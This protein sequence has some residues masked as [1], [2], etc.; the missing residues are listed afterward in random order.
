MS[1]FLTNFAVYMKR[2]PRY[3][4]SIEDESRLETK[5]AF[6]ASPL[7]WLFLGG[8]A[9][10]S[11]MV[12]GVFVV[13]LSPLRMLLPGYLKESERAET[14]MQ[15]LRLDSIR[16]A[17]EA[18]ASFLNN[19]IRVISPTTLAGASDGATVPE[20]ITAE[21]DTIPKSMR[22]PL[23][24]ASKEE[25]RFSAMMREREKYSISVIAPLAAE[26]LMFSPLSEESVFKESS[27]GAFKGEVVTAKGAPICAIADGT[28]IAVSQTI[29]DG[30]STI[31]IQHPKG[32]LSR[33]SRIGTVLVEPGDLVSG[34]QIIA[35]SNKGNARKAEILNI[36]MWYNGDPLV[37][38]DYIGDGMSA[39]SSG[40]LQD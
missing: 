5:A 32:F 4:I 19:I 11:I 30:G 29:R 17:Y 18:N 20:S 38:Y 25:E 16:M 6:S 8:V 33:C 2:R 23:L 24:S 14:E 36:E 39:G 37:P 35:L 22:T 26:S 12:L 34:G 27:K 10:L 1:R 15:L 3:K 21:T 31:I 28:V 9:V 40:G 7:R 13:F